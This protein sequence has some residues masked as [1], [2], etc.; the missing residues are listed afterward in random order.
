M[1]AGAIY[2]IVPWCISI[3]EVRHHNQVIPV[4]IVLQFGHQSFLGSG[5]QN[6][7]LKNGVVL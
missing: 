4:L 5:L 1:H 7:L 6:Q 2:Q 3:L